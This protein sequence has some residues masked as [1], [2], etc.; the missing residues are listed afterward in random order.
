[1][2]VQLL[3]TTREWEQLYW[4]ICREMGLCRIHGL[5]DIAKIYEPMLDFTKKILLTLYEEMLKK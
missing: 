2:S 5:D 3:I 1:M 4:R